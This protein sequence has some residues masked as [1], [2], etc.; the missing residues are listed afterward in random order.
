MQFARSFRGVPDGE[1]YPVDYEPGEECPPELERSAA[2]LKAFDAPDA[3]G[4]DDKL[5]VAQMREQ[6]TARGVAFDPA[7]KKADLQA[8]LDSAT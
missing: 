8:L 4:P 2:A 6:L 5:T 7:A 1:I 3:G